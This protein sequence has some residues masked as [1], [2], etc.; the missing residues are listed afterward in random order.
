MICTCLRAAFLLCLM[1][2]AA[3]A[4]ECCIFLQQPQ[5]LQVKAHLQGDA[6]YQSL[7]RDADSLLPKPYR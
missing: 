7:M 3:N 1:P 2:L 5:L 4:A 6:N